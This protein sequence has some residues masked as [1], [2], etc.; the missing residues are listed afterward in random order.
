MNFS[1]EIVPFNVLVTFLSAHKGV[2]VNFVHPP[3]SGMWKCIKGS[4][5]R[6]H[7]QDW[8]VFEQINPNDVYAASSCID[9][10]NILRQLSAIGFGR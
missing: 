6:L 8:S 5:V 4:A 7:V 1:I 2:R 9:V 10:F 3:A